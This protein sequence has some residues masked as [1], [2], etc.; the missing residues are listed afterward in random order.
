M[1]IEAMGQV[2]S[3]VNK[4]SGSMGGSARFQTA[5]IEP[6]ISRS[7]SGFAFS[8]VVN[9]GFA[10]ITVYKENMANLTGFNP[11][12]EIIF[13]PFKGQIPSVQTDLKVVPEAGLSAEDAVA[14]AVLITSKGTDHP[15]VENGLLWDEEQWAGIEPV[16]PWLELEKTDA[17]TKKAIP[18][19]SS[20]NEEARLPARQANLAENLQF[21]Q[22]K[23]ALEKAG[24]VDLSNNLIHQS[25]NNLVQVFELPSHL[26]QPVVEAVVR[27]QAFEEQEVQAAEKKKEKTKDALEQAEIEQEKIRYVLDEK[28]YGQ[29]VFEFKTAVDQMGEEFEGQAVVDLLPGE[30]DNNRSGIL[31]EIDPNKQIPDGSLIEAREEFAR[32]KFTSKQEAKDK[33]YAL[34]SEKEPARKDQYGRGLKEGSLER[35]YKYRP[36]KTPPQEE[37]VTRIVKKSQLVVSKDQTVPEVSLPAGI[38]GGIEDTPKI[39][40]PKIEDNLVLAELF[41]R[42]F[43]KG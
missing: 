9:E 39:K 17:H 19:A 37:V 32:L 1:G 12:G 4:A 41:Q 3:G 2:L 20:L 31:K 24:L 6:G 30:N 29:R 15:V 5:T 27:P 13:N 40:E 18:E 43:F 36:L 10:P 21:Q 33:A 7:F 16:N 14:E 23:A 22:T 11:R 34:V 42:N 28:A 8:Q 26:E 25:V 38:N 35:I